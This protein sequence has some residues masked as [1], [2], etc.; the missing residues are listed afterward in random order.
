MA[1]N[2][3]LAAQGVIMG[4]GQGSRL[5]ILTMFRSKPAVA[6]NGNLRII[7]FVLNNVSD[8]PEITDLI[9]LTQYQKTSLD[10][11]VSGGNIWG[12]GDERKITIDSPSEVSGGV[13]GIMPKIERY[14][15]T[16]D[17]IRKTMPRI[18]SKGLPLVLVLGGDHAYRTDYSQLLRQHVETE[19]DA[20]IMANVV[21]EGKISALGIM[22]VDVKDRILDFCEKPKSPDLVKDFKLDPKKVAE[23]GLNPSKNYYLASMGNY[24]FDREKLNQFLRDDGRD[25]FGKHIIPRLKE[26]GKNL[27]AYIYPDF[28]ADIGQIHDYFDFNMS[29][30]AGND[31]IDLESKIV[32]THLR[33]LPM[34]IVTESDVKYC[35]LSPGDKISNSHLNMVVV[36][37]QVVIKGSNVEY[38]MLLGA[39]RN[40]RFQKYSTKITGSTLDHVIVDKNVWMENVNLGPHNGSAEKRAET[41]V[42]AGLQPYSVNEGGGITGDFHIDQETRILTIRKQ[43]ELDSDKKRPL[44]Y[45]IRA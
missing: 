33:H 13:D 43:R 38:S 30:A 10:N 2:K 8:T 14:E 26:I 41:L 18:N 11:H 16:A 44:L 9:I 15:G 4:G 40:T 45:N 39:D 24:V 7:D 29:Y 12:F 3:K 27:Y 5:K 19:S 6:T 37:Y 22:K 35:I 42:K 20:T 34:T 25:D 23:L 31:P 21:E 32:K 17:A 36:G 28:W 1:V